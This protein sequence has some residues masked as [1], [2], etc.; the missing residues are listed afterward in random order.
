MLCLRGG[1]YLAKR[2]FGGTKVDPRSQTC[3]DTRAKS[4]EIAGAASARRH[5]DALV[6]RG[7]RLRRASPTAAAVAKAIARMRCMIESAGES[8]RSGLCLRSE[9]P[10]RRAERRV[11]VG[12]RGAADGS[13]IEDPRS[14]ATNDRG[15]RCRNRFP[16]ITM[17]EGMRGRRARTRRDEQTD[18]E[19]N[20]ARLADFRRSTSR[21]VGVAGRAGVGPFRRGTSRKR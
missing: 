12:T 17:V 16:G 13:G 5:H 21:R 10:R 15:P 14:S 2:G 7:R 4:G 6:G 3:F 1:K 11:V 9:R 18:V 20:R 19:T 8:T